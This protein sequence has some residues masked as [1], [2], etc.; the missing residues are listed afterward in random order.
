[1]YYNTR[2]CKKT[3]T[4]FSRVLRHP[5]SLLSILKKPGQ[6]WICF[7]IFTLLYVFVTNSSV[8]SSIVRYNK[9]KDIIVDIHVS[10]SRLNFFS[11][12]LPLLCL[13]KLITEFNCLFFSW[14]VIRP[15]LFSYLSHFTLILRQK[16]HSDWSRTPWNSL[17]SG[18]R[19]SG[20]V[21]F[22]DPDHA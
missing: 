7:L 8:N 10:N 9:N 22:L 21:M 5:A 20:S 6:N 3:K 14:L 4:R 2:K 19:H 15:K 13:L 17:K 16:Q 18:T 1:M 11:S 12:F